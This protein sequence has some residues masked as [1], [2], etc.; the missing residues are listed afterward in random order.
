MEGMMISQLTKITDSENPDC[1]S[2]RFMGDPVLVVMAGTV[3]TGDEVYVP[4]LGSFVHVT[5]QITKG[6]LSILWYERRLDA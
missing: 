6:D 1:G 2:F 3:D 4:H 5:Q